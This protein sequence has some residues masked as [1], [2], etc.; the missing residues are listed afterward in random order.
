[1]ERRAA[2]LG[3]MAA[4]DGLQRLFHARSAPVALARNLGLDLVQWLTPVKVSHADVASGKH[5]Q[6]S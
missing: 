3:M 4:L 6:L 5:R 2:N 1:M